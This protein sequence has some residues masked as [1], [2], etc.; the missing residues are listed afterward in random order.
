MG[1][2]EALKI[3]G[4]AQKRPNVGRRKEERKGGREGGSG[5]GN[6]ENAQNTLQSVSSRVGDG[7]EHNSGT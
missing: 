5:M 6:S 2:S 4:W 7:S 3:L 1:A